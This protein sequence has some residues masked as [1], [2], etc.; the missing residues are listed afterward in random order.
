[1]LMIIH[2]FIFFD[3]DD[4]ITPYYHLINYINRFGKY[5]VIFNCCTPR[6]YC[7]YSVRSMYI[8]KDALLQIVPFRMIGMNKEDM[9]YWINVMNTIHNKSLTYVYNINQNMNMYVYFQPT[10]SANKNYKKY[11]IN[12][13]NAYIF[14]V[15]MNISYMKK[16]GDIIKYISPIN[17]VK[18]IPINDPFKFEVSNV[19]KLPFVNY[20]YFYDKRHYRLYI[21]WYIG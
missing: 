10:S 7:E 13:M 19:E 16:Y 3:D 1:M 15:E 8:R 11:D 12:R 4:I 18:C 9:I 6:V 20:L 17:A 21:L 2:I 14:N 5:Q